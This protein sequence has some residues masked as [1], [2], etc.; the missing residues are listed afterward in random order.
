MKVTSIRPAAGVMMLTVSTA[1]WPAVD[2]ANAAYE[3]GAGKGTRDGTAYNR[4]QLTSPYILTTR[5]TALPL[6]R[7]FLIPL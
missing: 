2:T 5:Y 6:K 4:W 3:T 7:E 1:G